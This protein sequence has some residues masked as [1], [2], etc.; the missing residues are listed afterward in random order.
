MSNIDKLVQAAPL[1]KSIVDIQSVP[2]FQIDQNVTTVVVYGKEHVY[3][4]GSNKDAQF[5]VD[6]M[7]QYMDKLFTIQNSQIE[8]AIGVIFYP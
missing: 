8:S 4:F 6:S 7:N 5:F 3:N 1:G 2:K